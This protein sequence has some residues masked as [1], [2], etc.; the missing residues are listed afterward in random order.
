MSRPPGILNISRVSFEPPASVAREIGRAIMSFSYLETAAEMMI[1][2]LLN[3]SFDDGSLITSRMQA[4]N[5][6]ALLRELLER[7]TNDKLMP[8]KQFWKTLKTLSEARAKIAH[9]AWIMVDREMPMI[10]SHRFSGPRDVVM[11]ESLPAHPVEGIHQAYEAGAEGTG[12]Y[13]GRAWIAARSI[14]SAT[15]AGLTQPSARSGM[16]PNLVR[17][18]RTEWRRCSPSR[19]PG[20]SAVEQIRIYAPQ[21]PVE[22]AIQESAVPV[23]VMSWSD[24][25]AG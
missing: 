5:K 7:P 14:C 18:R 1:W 20:W 17:R 3:L 8:T 9:G 22:R 16:K 6:F 12:S 23:R 11:G 13:F 25:V 24:Y 21:D 2:D 15:S 10:M 19:S 4:D